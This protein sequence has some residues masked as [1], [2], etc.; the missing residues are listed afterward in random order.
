M[1]IALCI[2]SNGDVKLGFAI[3]LAQ[4]FASPPKDAELAI[5]T[6]SSSILPLSRTSLVDDAR[7][8]GADYILWL[9][10]DH[11]FPPETPW[12]LLR[13]GLDVVGCNY[14]RRSRDAAP[15]AR[16]GP[17]LA[18]VTT[19]RDA[20]RDKVQKVDGMGLGLCLMRASVFD[21]IER[22][23]FVQTPDLGEDYY[24]FNKLREAGIELYVDHRA[25]MA[26]GHISEHI[27]TNADTKGVRLADIDLPTAGAA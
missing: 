13:R 16:I 21:R 9:D 8:W 4:L 5:I 20:E 14:P 26:V 3:S 11:V 27:L 19:Q 12:Q 22:P 2:P 7:R 17:G 6:S 15:T 25:S 24:L 1:K 18:V 23:W 10:T